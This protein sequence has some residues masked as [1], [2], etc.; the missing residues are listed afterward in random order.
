MSNLSFSHISRKLHPC[1]SRNQHPYDVDNHACQEINT[2]KNHT[3][4]NKFHPYVIPDN[5]THN[6]CDDVNT[7]TYIQD[8]NFHMMS[9]SYPL[10]FKKIT[11][12]LHVKTIDY[13]H[14]I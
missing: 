5:N 2:H 4:L 13:I 12:T 11:T 10:D 6:T 3:F 1:K 9:F 14:V 8:I 7:I